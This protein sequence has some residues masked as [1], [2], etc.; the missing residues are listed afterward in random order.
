MPHNEVGSA[1]CSL[2]D[3]I[4]KVGRVPLAWGRVLQFV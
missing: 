2:S 4:K 1:Y 3:D